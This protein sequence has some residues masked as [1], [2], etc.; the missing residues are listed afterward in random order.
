[1]AEHPPASFAHGKAAGTGGWQ[2]HCARSLCSFLCLSSCLSP[3]PRGSNQGTAQAQGYAPTP[4]TRPKPPRGGGRTELWGREKRWQ[5]GRKDEDGLG[6][7]SAGRVPLSGEGR[8][9][10]KQKSPRRPR[11]VRLVRWGLHGVCARSLL[12]VWFRKRPGRVALRLTRPWAYST[13]RGTPQTAQGWEGG[14]IQISRTHSPV[15]HR[16]ASVSA[17]PPPP[18]AREGSRAFCGSALAA[19]TLPSVPVPEK[20]SAA[21]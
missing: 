21:S 2:P 20:H 1:M 18:A 11:A 15:G 7:P 5:E 16:D 3:P 12:M 9:T 10:E 8:G 14:W 17:P 19:P 13:G 4:S 6:C